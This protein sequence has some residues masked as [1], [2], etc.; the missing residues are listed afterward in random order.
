MSDSLKCKVSKNHDGSLRFTLI[1]GDF[2][3]VDAGELLTCEFGIGRE[4]S[5]GKLAADAVLAE[6][7]HAAEEREGKRPKKSGKGAKA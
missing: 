6:A 1:D 7:A 4:D 2:P 3:D 5:A